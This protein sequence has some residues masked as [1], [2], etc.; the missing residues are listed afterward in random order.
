MTTQTIIWGIVIILGI[1]AIA[2]W[3]T[4]MYIGGQTPNDIFLN[5]MA[6]RAVAV[7]LVFL[8]GLILIIAFF[9]G[10]LK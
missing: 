4:G 10:A 5:Q 2:A 7:G 8:I 1:G 3:I 9:L 6:A